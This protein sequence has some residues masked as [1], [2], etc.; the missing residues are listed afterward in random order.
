M[1]DQPEFTTC[2]ICHKKMTY[3]KALGHVCWKCKRLKRS[4]AV[5]QLKT[6]QRCPEC[7]HKITIVPC[8]G[9]TMQRNLRN[10]KKES[11]S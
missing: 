8:V 11:Q 7:G 4:N 6:P 2:K 3:R 10:A 9:C 1:E 5:T